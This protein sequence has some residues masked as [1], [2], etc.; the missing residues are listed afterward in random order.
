MNKLS[1]VLVTVTVTDIMAWLDVTH[2]SMI[3]FIGYYSV[4]QAACY[5]YLIDCRWIP[6]SVLDTSNK[7]LK[8]LLLQHRE[9]DGKIPE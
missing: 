8:P 6:D 1:G 2:L 5:R 3:G 4:I 7:P 9:M